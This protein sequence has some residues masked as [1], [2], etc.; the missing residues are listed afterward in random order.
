MIIIII[1][2]VVVIIIVV[3]MIIIII[4]AP[5]AFAASTPMPFPSWNVYLEYL[6]EINHRI[7]LSRLLPEFKAIRKVSEAISLIFG[8]FHELFIAISLVES[9]VVHV[10][11]VFELF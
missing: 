9:P 2:I 10:A 6:I 7:V 11:T 3:I 5:W 1:I 4:F 8:E